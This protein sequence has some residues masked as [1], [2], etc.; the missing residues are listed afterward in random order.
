MNNLRAI[1]TATNS[2]ESELH[3]F[4]SASIIGPDGKTPHSWRV[5]LLPYLGYKKLFDRYKLNEPWDSESNRKILSEMPAEY[6]AVYDSNN[7]NACYF[8][9]TGR[10]TLFP[11]DKTFRMSGIIDGP[12][13]TLLAVEAKRDIPWTK[14]EDL[15]YAPDKPLPELGGFDPDG[16]STVFVDTSRASSS[17]ASSTTRQSAP[18]SRPPVERM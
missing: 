5:A 9:L 7:T 10:T 8:V 15:S 1:A 11:P 14:P 18:G 16:F 6:R 2:Y 13:N 17:E 3:H 12:A 4:P